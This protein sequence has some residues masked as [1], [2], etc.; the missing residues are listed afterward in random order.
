MTYYERIT[1]LVGEYNQLATYL[2]SNAITL[3][4]LL[5]NKD[6]I[7]TLHSELIL[8]KIG[9]SS[10]VEY[11]KFM[12]A[13]KKEK[14]EIITSSKLSIKMQDEIKDFINF[15]IYLNNSFF[16]DY[17]GGF[18][19][20]DIKVYEKAIKMIND[21]EDKMRKLDKEIYT[22]ISKLNNEFLQSN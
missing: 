21:K 13:S 18:S 17:D 14:E 2:F 6:D 16:I 5:N 8:N 1:F 9:A 4:S 10:K 15:Q 20:E 11:Q 12:D 3:I 7:N 22:L 19:S